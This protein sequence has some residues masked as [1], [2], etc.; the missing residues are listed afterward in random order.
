[1]AGRPKQRGNYT[2]QGQM[3]NKVQERYRKKKMQ[4]MDEKLRKKLRDRIRYLNKKEFLSSAE[5]RE[6][7]KLEKQI[8]N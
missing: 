4:S 3:K 6:K 5:I 1:M 8:N 7:R 2:G